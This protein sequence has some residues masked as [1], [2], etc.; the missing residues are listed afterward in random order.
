MIKNYNLFIC[1]YINDLIKKRFL[2]YATLFSAVFLTDF[3]ADFGSK[4][5]KLIL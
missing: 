5:N 4:K 1:C 3:S 2:I